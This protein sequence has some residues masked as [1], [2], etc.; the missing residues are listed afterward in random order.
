MPMR[1]L[2]KRLGP[3]GTRGK[4]TLVY[5]PADTRSVDETALD[6]LRRELTALEAAETRISAERR[7]LHERID[8][9]FA[10]AE[11]RAREREVSDERRRLHRRIDS[12]RERLHAQDPL[13]ASV[14]TAPE[15]P[16]SRLS[17]WEGISPEVAGADDSCLDEPEP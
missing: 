10:T 6:D 4:F 2:G 3:F 17:Q 11:T 15:S 12:L 5:V 8:F 13:V 14:E 7:R 1:E 9:G 16:L